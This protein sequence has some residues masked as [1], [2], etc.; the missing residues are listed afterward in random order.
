[1]Y[2]VIIAGYIAVGI[3]MCIL[4]IRCMLHFRSSGCKVLWRNCVAYWLALLL[5]WPIVMIVSRLYMRRHPS[6]YIEQSVDKW[7][8]EKA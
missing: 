6:P 5:F 8:K 7:L 4:C 2:K 3:V 1:M